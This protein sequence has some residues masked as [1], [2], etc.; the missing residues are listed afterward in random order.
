M[1]KPNKLEWPEEVEW[2]KDVQYILDLVEYIQDNIYKPDDFM[3]KAKAI[4]KEKG[5]KNAFAHL[6]KNPKVIVK[7]REK[8][9]LVRSNSNYKIKNPIEILE[10]INYAIAKIEDAIERNLSPKYV[11]FSEK[12]ND[13]ERVQNSL[14]RVQFKI[15]VRLEE[16]KVKEEDGLFILFRNIIN[17]VTRHYRFFKKNQVNSELGNPTIDSV[18]NQIKELVPNDR[19]KLVGSL[20]LFEYFKGYVLRLKEERIKEIL[21]IISNDRTGNHLLKYLKMFINSLSSKEKP[22]LVS[23][24]I[25]DLSP[26]QRE[27]LII[28]ILKNIIESENDMKSVILGI[29][30]IKK[31][32]NK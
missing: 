18:L 9:I 6:E 13:L 14:R 28:K 8:A 11:F 26:K 19:M 20:D 27:K 1:S 31:K 22:R 5:K 15:D 4:A 16:L 10:K 23:F 30:E 32:F 25:K 2:P 21:S 3:E 17:K 7:A 29:K 24:L 12:I